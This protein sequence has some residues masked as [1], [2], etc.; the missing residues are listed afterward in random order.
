MLSIAINYHVEGSL[1]GKQEATWVAI[2]VYGAVSPSVLFWAG[3]R[4]LLIEH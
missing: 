2:F 3:H 4:L 1:L